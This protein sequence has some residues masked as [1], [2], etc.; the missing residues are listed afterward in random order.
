M[1]VA[2]GEPPPLAQVAELPTDIIAEMHK[3]W[4][5]SAELNMA[6]R[7]CRSLLPAADPAAVGLLTELSRLAIDADVVRRKMLRHGDE[8]AAPPGPS[9]AH[10]A[11]LAATE[12]VPFIESLIGRYTAIA[13]L[14]ETDIRLGPDADAYVATTELVG[15]TGKAEGVLFATKR[16]VSEA[17]IARPSAST[18]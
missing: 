8:S 14:L 9:T 1:T 10:E 15:L 17:P 3:K 12:T 16:M 13:D 4:P 7:A 6:H 2:D 18:S 11:K 5:T